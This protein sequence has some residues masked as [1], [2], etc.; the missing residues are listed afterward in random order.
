MKAPRP[1]QPP[2]LQDAVAAALPGRAPVAAASATPAV[3][4]EA[5]LRAPAREGRPAIVSYLTAGFPT[6]D[7][8]AAL[9]PR[10]AAVSDAVEVGVPFSDPI[11]DGVTI[12]RASHVALEAGT[13]LRRILAFLA[14]LSPRPVASILLM[15]YLNPLLA[16]GLTEVAAAAQH[17]GVAGMIVPDLPL[18]ECAPL[19]TA[20]AAHG[21]ALV[22]LVT[23]VTPPPRLATLCDASTGFVYAVTVTGTT[24]GEVAAADVLSAY[25]DR[26]R[27][28]ARVPVLAG[29]GIRTQAQVRQ[30][31]RHADGVVVGSALLELVLQ[32]EDPVTFLRS[33]RSS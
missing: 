32:G 8:F 14:E 24:G 1:H 7:R 28:V 18:E 11:A 29:F 6:F 13:S 15:S 17:A 9:L 2:D 30:L 27:A 12:Q 20:L 26:V 21:L 25:L 33:L 19:R 23:P 31:A 3:R 4:L 5:A 10:V 22:Q 16:Y